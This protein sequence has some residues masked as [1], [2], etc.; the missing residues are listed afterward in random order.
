MVSPTPL[1]RFRVSSPH[2]EM[3][4]VMDGA[5]WDA[6]RALRAHALRSRHEVAQNAELADD[7]HDSAQNAVTFLLKRNGRPAGTTRASVSSS[8]R[9][10][11]LP[12]IEVFGR[13]IEA[14]IG[15]DAT[16]VEASLTFVA[17]DLPDDPRE[18]LFHLFKAHLLVCALERAD[19]LVM[20]VP[21]SQIGF[22]RRMFNMEILSGSERYA[23]L[24]FPRVLMGLDYREQAGVLFK[25]IPLVQIGERDAGEFLQ[26][27]AVL[28]HPRAGQ[29]AGIP[30]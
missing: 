3:R 1:D 15:W 27:G 22:H 14:S 12:S 9:R 10:W 23:P 7:G 5:A 29:T 28:F 25:R 18:S 19:W 2:F 11:P 21:E 17:P 20:A 26:T 8:E 16:I 30:A 24:A 13:E 4:R 6:V